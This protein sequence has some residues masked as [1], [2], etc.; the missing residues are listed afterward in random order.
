MTSIHVERQ[1]N[2]HGRIE[3]KQSF[4][5]KQIASV[6]SRRFQEL[7]IL[8]TEKCN[9]RCTYCYEDFK[10][11]KMSVVTQRAL[12]LFVERRAP[13][14]EKLV[15]SWF[16]GEPLVAHDVVL[17]LARFADRICDAQGV[18]FSGGLTTN[19]FL[20]TRSLFE[21]LLSCKQDFFQIT[22][23]G[24][25][26]THDQVRKFADGRGTFDT[27]WKN[28]EAMKSVKGHFEVVLRIHVRRDNIE[29]LPVL[30]RKVAGTFGDDNRFRMDFEHV[31]DLG[32]AGGASVKQ[33]VHL[34]E[35]HEVEKRLRQIYREEL[36]KL[37]GVVDSIAV[38]V[39]A[40]TEIQEEE[41]LALL[42]QKMAGESA[43]SR[44]ASDIALGQP[45]IC[46]AAKANS[47]L[48]RANGRVGKCTVALSDER[49]DIGHIK[50][51]GSF[52]IFNE[53]LK[54][55]MRGLSNLDEEALTCP[56]KDMHKVR[57]PQLSTNHG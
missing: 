50:P 22:L 51:D 37:N 17:R 43:G 57:T 14:L 23:D 16:G 44:R 13:G 33:P 36:R 47:L 26:K 45:Y 15:F 9:F 12:E 40:V 46:Y 31:R 7:I 4:T 48:I 3:E 29:A 25:G 49:N 56:L 11:G 1:A 19:G 39:G 52:E 27:I 21:D 42:K 2:I 10:I 18:Q 5:P 35:L 38:D 28:L 55:W 30:M 54:P 34:K 32:G 41:N 24:W 53:K 6:I 8:P 20:L